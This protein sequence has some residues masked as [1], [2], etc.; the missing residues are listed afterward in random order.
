MA[1]FHRRDPR[2]RMFLLRSDGYALRRELPPRALDDF[3]QR[4]LARG[5]PSAAKSWERADQFNSPDVLAAWPSDIIRPERALL[6]RGEPGKTGAWLE[7]AFGPGVGLQE[8]A[9]DLERSLLGL[10]PSEQVVAEAAPSR[11][12]APIIP[13]PVPIVASE[14]AGQPSAPSIQVAASWPRPLAHEGDPFT[15]AGSGSQAGDL[16]LGVDV[17][18][19]DLPG[20]YPGDRL[21]SPRRGGCVFVHLDATRR[22]ALLRDERGR[23][24]AVDYAE[25]TT[26]FSFDDESEGFPR[27]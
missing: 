9:E 7:A 26:E 16:D 1:W 13:A 5:G 19:V 23:D 12:V 8:L 11:V 17:R 25:L 14:P 24:L 27:A 4:I 15:L 3:V 22:Q 21:V 18:L 10:A 6:G 2:A 20:L